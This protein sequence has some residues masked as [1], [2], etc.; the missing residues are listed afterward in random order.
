MCLK[1]EYTDIFNIS[2]I[3]PELGGHA[4]ADSDLIIMSDLIRLVCLFSATVVVCNNKNMDVVN[5]LLIRSQ[6]L[7]TQPWHNQKYTHNNTY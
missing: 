7:I 1:T 5:K 2:I 6:S 3:S 4:A